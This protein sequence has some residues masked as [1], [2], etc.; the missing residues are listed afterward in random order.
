MV[1][2]EAAKA[3]TNVDVL[4]IDDEESV[5]E[6]CRHTLDLEGYRTHLAP[7]GLGGLKLAEETRPR[8]AVV[9][10]RM[11]GLSGIEVLERLPA[12][13]ARIV[14]VVITGFGTVDNAV[15]SMKLGAFEFITK[16]FEPA[17][18][19]DAVRRGVARSLGREHAMAT[20]ERASAAA[21]AARAPEE[22]DV[23]L[24]GLEALS[25]GYALGLT[26]S[27]L[28]EELR[29]LEAEAKHHAE[30]L[31]QIKKR[32]KVIGDLVADLRF[33]DAIIQK[34]DFRKNALIQILLDIQSKKH[35]LPRHALMW[36][37]R[38]LNVPL[39]RIYEIANF[40]EA[41]SLTPQGA[42]LIQVCLGT[43]CHVRGGPLLL[44]QVSA[45]LGIGA[46][47]TDPKGIFTLKSVNC[48]GCCALAPVV[49]VD[50]RY[51]GNPDLRQLREL[52]Q[53][54]E[55]EVAT[56]VAAS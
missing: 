33:V 48:L 32:E 14:P 23:I 6:S 35:W 36:V 44:K 18:L 5:R 42:H 17:Q 40:Y 11:P 1:Q 4:V 19:V 10:L 47:Q 22:P 21:T 16:P 52:F 13:D 31:G 28:V 37:S 26:A 3:P 30:T 38:R 25:E 24:K 15:A 46:G 7:D 51:Y 29:Q 54:C 9:D 43:A 53:A 56:E 50:G 8:V 55:A 39:S 45:V 20:A 34:H 12:I 27:N 2:T 49:T 41:F